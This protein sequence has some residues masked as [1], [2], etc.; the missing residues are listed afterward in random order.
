LQKATTSS[1]FKVKVAVVK[2]NNDFARKF[3]PLPAAFDTQSSITVV[4]KRA[5]SDSDANPIAKRFRV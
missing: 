1:I 4:R 2:L 3:F 5:Y